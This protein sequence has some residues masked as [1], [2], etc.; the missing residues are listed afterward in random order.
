MYPKE[1]EELRKGETVWAY[2]NPLGGWVKARVGKD[3]IRDN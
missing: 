2:T 3:V 1:A